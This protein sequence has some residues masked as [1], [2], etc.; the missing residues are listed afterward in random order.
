MSAHRSEQLRVKKRHPQRAIASHGD[1][2]E[3]AGFA[4][5]GNSVA[6][7]DPGHEFLQEEIVVTEA[8]VVRVHEETGVTGWADQNEI[9][10]LPAVPEFLDKIE[11]AGTHEHLLIITKPVEVIEHGIAAIGIFAVA[12]RQDHTV[13]NRAAQ[14]AAGH[15]KTFA[16]GL[17]SWRWR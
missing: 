6:M 2:A 11:S 15:G 9:A 13:R 12:R 4:A 5:R 3:A 14:D 1:T 8:P 17:S 16:T 7:L 10:D